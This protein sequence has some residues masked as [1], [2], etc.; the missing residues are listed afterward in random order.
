MRAGAGPYRLGNDPIRQ[1]KAPP[2]H[3]VDENDPTI[4]PDP[5]EDVCAEIAEHDA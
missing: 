5:R 1:P 4:A 2:E 3:L